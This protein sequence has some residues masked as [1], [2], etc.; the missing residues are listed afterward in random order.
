MRLFLLLLSLALTGCAVTQH[1]PTGTKY[2][3]VDNTNNEV[4]LQPPQRDQYDPK[5]Y[6]DVNVPFANDL[7]EY[8]AYIDRELSKVRLRAGLEGDTI[9]PL[10]STCTVFVLPERGVEPRY[11]PSTLDSNEIVLDETLDYA[12][13]LKQYYAAWADQVYRAYAQYQASCKN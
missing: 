3:L 5:L 12:K 10:P 13:A 7:T 11:Q 6:R 9:A 2:S 4:V 8:R 1:A